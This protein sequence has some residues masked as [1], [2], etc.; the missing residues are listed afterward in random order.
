MILAIFGGIIVAAIVFAVVYDY[1]AKRRGWRAGPLAKQQFQDRLDVRAFDAIPF[2]QDED[3]DWMAWRQ[4]N[5]EP[6]G[7]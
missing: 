1:R 3:L 6:D 5:K 2:S 4:R 7:K